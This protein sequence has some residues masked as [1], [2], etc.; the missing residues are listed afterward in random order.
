MA[1]F[2]LPGPGSLP[3]AVTSVST[4]LVAVSPVSLATQKSRRGWASSARVAPLGPDWPVEPWSPTVAPGCVA[5]AP[6]DLSSRGVCSLI[7]PSWPLTRSR[8]DDN[9]DQ[10]VSY[11]TL[12]QIG[13][14]CR[15]LHGGR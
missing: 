6:V 12:L 3:W 10:T 11:H 14:A 4:R 5:P 2:K 7:R 13:L 15:T 1:R 9:R 8:T